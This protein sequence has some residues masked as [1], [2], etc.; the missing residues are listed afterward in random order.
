MTLYELAVIDLLVIYL[1]LHY[2]L[3]NLFRLEPD[4]TIWYDKIRIRRDVV[5]LSC[6]VEIS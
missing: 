4:K 1:L 5:S 3:Q 2:K 6:F